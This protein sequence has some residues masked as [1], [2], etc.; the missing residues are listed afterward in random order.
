MAFYMFREKAYDQNITRVEKNGK[1]LL[2][3]EAL[4]G[5]T[6]EYFFTIPTPSPPGRARQ[7]SCP[8][9]SGYMHELFKV[10]LDGESLPL[11]GP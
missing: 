3:Y 2:I 4:Y 9:V 7:A 5:N 11:S 10:M 1:D 8:D 6:V